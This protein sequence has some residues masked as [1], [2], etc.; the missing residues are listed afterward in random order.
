[1]SPFYIN[2][3]MT[4]KED[5]LMRRREKGTIIIITKHFTNKVFCT[6]HLKNCR[7]RF[8]SEAE[9]RF[10]MHLL[11]E[12]MRKNTVFYYDKNVVKH[13]LM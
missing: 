12:F 9:V 3:V 6:L 1:M 7:C 4:K 10:Y 8:N 13:L 5:I 11:V 2:L